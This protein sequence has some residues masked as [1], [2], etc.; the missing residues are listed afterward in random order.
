MEEPS[1]KRSPGKGRGRLQF[2]AGFAVAAIALIAI[3]EVALRAAPP[4]N[5][6][7][8]L[9]DD[10]TP[11]PFRSDP[12]YGVQ[13]KSWQAFHDEYWE[14]LIP[15]EKLFTEPK[16]TTWA[17]FGSS[18]VH[19]TGMLADTTRKFVP[20]RHVFNLGR[21]EF[22]Y[23]RAAQ[24]ELLLENGLKPERILF[25]LMPLDISVLARHTFAM[26]HA[27]KNGALDY[28]PRLPPVGGAIIRDSRLALTG[29]VRADMQVAIPFFNPADMTKRMDPRVTDET[30]YLFEIIA[31]ATERHH[32]PVTVL[33]I[34][35]WE[36][37]TKGA[38]YAFQD[39]LIPLASNAGFDVLDVRDVFRNYPDK[40]ALFIPDKHFSDLGN[41]ILLNEFVK[42]LQALGEA[43]DVKLPEGF[44]E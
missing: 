6:Q 37:V 25:A 42:H 26:V 31:K 32:V 15:H 11:G 9:A 18:F 17:M 8:Y 20:N 28:E 30:R 21:N 44:P 40:S 19:A 1:A 2:A 16:P 27:G 29:W 34:P 22:V 4:R 3:G 12:I 33:L 13:Y 35:N 7:P 38:G 39:A 23:V 24:I 43:A 10:D 41:R 5:V 36:Q 14:E